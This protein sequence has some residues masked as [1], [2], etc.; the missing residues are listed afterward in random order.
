[1]HAQKSEPVDPRYEA[2]PVSIK[3]MITPHEYAWL[4]AEAQARIEQTEAEPDPEP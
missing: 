4:G 2:L 1:M 3:A